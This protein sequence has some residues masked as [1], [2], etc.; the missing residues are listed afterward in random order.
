MV[1]GHHPWVFGFAHDENR[2]RVKLHLRCIKYAG[3][4][5][6][7]DFSTTFEASK[8]VLGFYAPQALFYAL[9]IFVYFL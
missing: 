6:T 3:D 9:A 8:V 7:N 1:I 4:N 5:Y 2:Y